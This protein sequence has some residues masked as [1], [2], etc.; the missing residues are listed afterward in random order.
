MMPQTWTAMAVECKMKTSLMGLCAWM[1]GPLLVVLFGK[2][3]G[4][5]DGGA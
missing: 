5:L 1:L 4:L 3:V 2:A